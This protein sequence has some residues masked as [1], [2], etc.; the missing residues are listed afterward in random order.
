MKQVQ[1]EYLLRHSLL[2]TEPDKRPGAWFSELTVS[3]GKL[4]QM[5][6]K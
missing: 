4:P 2:T 6:F 5:K 1:P 3:S